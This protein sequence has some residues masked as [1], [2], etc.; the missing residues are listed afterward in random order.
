MSLLF[1]LMLASQERISIK[2][3]QVRKKCTKFKKLVRKMLHSKIQL[4]MWRIFFEIWLFFPKKKPEN[5]AKYSFCHFILFCIC[6]KFPTQKM[7]YNHI[8]KF[9]PIFSSHIWCPNFGFTNI[10]KSFGQWQC[11]KSMDVILCFEFGNFWFLQNSLYS[12][13]LGNFNSFRELLFA[14]FLINTKNQPTINN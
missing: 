11:W 6:E 10:Q 14:D 12:F 1:N 8:I 7:L 9:Q 4:K 13:I 3:Q 2:W 5:R